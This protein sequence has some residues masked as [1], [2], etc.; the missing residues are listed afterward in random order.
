VDRG[1]FDPATAARMLE[2]LAV[3]IAA[4]AADPELPLSALP[5]LSPAAP[6]GPCPRPPGRT[7]RP[8]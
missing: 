4:A 5:L 7:I 3:L 1:L 8:T 2:E 6:P